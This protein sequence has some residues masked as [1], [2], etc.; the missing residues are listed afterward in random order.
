M[1]RWM[2][3]AGAIVASNLDRWSF[4]ERVGGERGDALALLHRPF[5]RPWTTSHDDSAEAGQFSL[6]SGNEGA[7]SPVDWAKATDARWARAM[8]LDADDTVYDAA[9]REFDRRHLE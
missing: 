1:T 3:A 6:T 2:H 9:W 4:E 7:P 5:A 8:A